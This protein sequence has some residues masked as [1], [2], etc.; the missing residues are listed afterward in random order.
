MSMQGGSSQPAASAGRVGLD[1]RYGSV[2]V[3]LLGLAVAACVNTGQI[4]NLTETHRVT[5]AFESIEGPPPAVFHKL[6]KSLKE[7]AGAR[8]I[9]VVSPREANYRVR[10]YL[11]AHGD[12]GTAPI[13][14]ISWAL[15]VYDVDQRRAFRLN[16][17]E[18]TAG[19][20]WAAA[21]DQALQR[22]ART[23]M[24]RFALLSAT[25]HPPS[26]SVTAAS[27]APQRT[28][29]ALGWLDDWAPEASG[30][31]RILRREPAKGPEI[32]ADAGSQVPPREVPL[33]RGRPAPSGV[34]TSVMPDATFAF[35]PESE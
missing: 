11:A 20:M 2:G 13:T 4:A 6:M 16:G 24:E 7:E 35:A 17:E 27:P 19:R 25:A 28:A 34:T 12:E 32:A 15:D 29:S 10:S 21:D 22:I 9:T 30:I 33:P 26:G 3:L 8:Q 5:V 31:V 18:K 1:R 23:S 14:T